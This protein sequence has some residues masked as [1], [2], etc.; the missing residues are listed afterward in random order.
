MKNLKLV[1]TLFIGIILCIHMGNVFAQALDHPEYANSIAVGLLLLALIPKA[2]GVLAVEISPDISAIARFAFANKIKLLKR[3]YNSLSIASDITLMLNIKNSLPLPMLVI[4]GQPR[5]YDGKFSATPGDIS[6]T[7]RQ[8]DMDDFQRD[9]QI[10]PSLYRPTY[11]A[12]ERGPGEGIKNNKIPFAEFTVQGAIDQN[13][14][15]LNNKT[16]FFGLGKAAFETF[17]PATAYL[18]GK[19]VKALNAEGIAHYYTCKIG[20]AAGETPYSHPLKWELSDALAVAEGLGT[21]IKKER[22][23]GLIKNVSSTGIIT[24]EDAFEQALSVYRG[25]PEEVKDNR[26]DI[27]LYVSSNTIDKISDSF[28]D[29]IKKYTDADG[30]LTVL[31]RTEGICKLKKATWMNGSDIMLASPKANLYMGTDLLSDL[32]DL[33]TIEQMYHLDMSLKGVLGFQFGDEQAISINDQN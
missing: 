5:P 30:V 2:K 9:I 13:A 17:N 24:K 4:N 14:A 26:K 20:T 33:R 11:L 25:L 32:Q 8:L 31:P 28:K 18:T 3:Y 23:S 10:N 12:Y 27:Y 21:K 16:A 7:D 29:Y 19:R 22:A 1:F 15:Q 6:Y